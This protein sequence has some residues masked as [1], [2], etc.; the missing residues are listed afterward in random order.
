M[1]KGNPPTMNVMLL[2]LFFLLFIMAVIETSP[3]KV[4]LRGQLGRGSSSKKHSHT[5]TTQ[6]DLKPH[7]KKT[8]ATVIQYCYGGTDGGT[9]GGTHR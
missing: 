6:T 2:M 5:F 9:Y 3:T 7:K 8:K 1:S 4:N